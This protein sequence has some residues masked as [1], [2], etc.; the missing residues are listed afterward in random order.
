MFAHLCPAVCLSTAFPSA[1]TDTSNSYHTLALFI[2]VST[3]EQFL[4]SPFFFL[5]FLCQ[6]PPPL[7]LF[8]LSQPS[9]AEPSPLRCISCF[10]ISEPL[11][12][13]SLTWLHVF[14]HISFFY[15]FVSFF[16][17]FSLFLETLTFTFFMDVFYIDRLSE[18]NLIRTSF[19]S[20]LNPNINLHLFF[21]RK[22]M[23]CFVNHILSCFSVIL[24]Q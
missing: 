19:T 5:S 17:A 4:L 14:S 11:I 2:S 16:S 24:F 15:F 18:M 10:Q 13:A 23:I 21:L 12:N 1:Y 3:C 7:Q 22:S 20:K 8:D 6:T 9:W